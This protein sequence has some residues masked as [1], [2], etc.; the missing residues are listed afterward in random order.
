MVELYTG[1]K[2]GEK[3]KAIYQKPLPPRNGYPHFN[4]HNRDQPEELFF[5]SSIK[6]D[7]STPKIK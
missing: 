4:F 2:I 5:D 3:R 6:L 7:A 1:E